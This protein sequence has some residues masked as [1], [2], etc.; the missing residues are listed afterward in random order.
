M[1]LPVRGAMLPG[2][3]SRTVESHFSAKT[4]QPD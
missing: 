1:N 3:V 2:N 4:L